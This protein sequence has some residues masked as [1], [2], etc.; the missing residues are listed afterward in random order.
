[1]SAECLTALPRAEASCSLN[2]SVSRQARHTCKW[3]EG[4]MYGRMTNRDSGL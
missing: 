1:M 4:D 2:A 3:L